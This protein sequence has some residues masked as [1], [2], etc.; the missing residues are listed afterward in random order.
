M[1][2]ILASPSLFQVPAFSLTLTTSQATHLLPPGLPPRGSTYPGTLGLASF[3][4]EPVCCLPGSSPTLQ[5]L[6][7]TFHLALCVLA[8][9]ETFCC[10]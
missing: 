9:L 10:K 5:V 6:T 1:V 8:S 2:H 3:L 4:P 7:F